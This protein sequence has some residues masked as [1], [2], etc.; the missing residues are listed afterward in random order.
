MIK[1][2][3]MNDR[4]NNTDELPVLEPLMPGEDP[5]PE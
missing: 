1:E 3:D 5:P 2:I 4:L